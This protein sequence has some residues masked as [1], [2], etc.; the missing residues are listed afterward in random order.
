MRFMFCGLCISPPRQCWATSNFDLCVCVC[1]IVDHIIRA[2]YE[3]QDEEE[4]KKNTTLVAM[5]AAR[6]RAVRSH[7]E[8]CRK[9]SYSTWSNMTM[10]QHTIDMQT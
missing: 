3:T 9:S 6:S 7:T 8:H 10:E 1:I 4:V 5:R 2:T